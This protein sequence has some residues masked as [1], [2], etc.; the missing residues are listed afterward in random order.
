MCATDTYHRWAAVPDSDWPRDEAG[1]N[2]VLRDFEGALGDRRQE[3][4]FIGVGMDED[5]ISAQV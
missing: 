1:R 5:K 3:I 2:V 4:V